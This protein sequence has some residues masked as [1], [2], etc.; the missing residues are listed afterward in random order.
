[1]VRRYGRVAFAVAEP[2]R[3]AG[4]QHDVVGAGAAEDRLM[5]IVAHRVGVRER[6]QIGRVALLN[7]E[8]EHRRRTFANI[9]G[10]LRRAVGA[11]GDGGLDPGKEIMAATRRVVLGRGAGGAIELL[12]HLEQAM[13]GARR[14]GVVRERRGMVRLGQL[15]GAGGQMARV[16]AVVVDP[17]VGYEC[18]GGVAAALLAGAPVSRYW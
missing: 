6:L 5:V 3:I 13:H 15:E 10:G 16:L 8:K 9:V 12:P 4:A 17:R 14:V 2:D 1:V 18:A 7:I 11:G